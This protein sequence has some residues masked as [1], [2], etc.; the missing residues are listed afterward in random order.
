MSS[1]QNSFYLLYPWLIKYPMIIDILVK[2]RND[3]GISYISQKEIG[4]KLGFSP[5]AISK[6]LRRLEQYDQCVE[7]IAPGQYIVHHTDMMHF[8][9][10]SKVIAFHNAAAKD[11][12][13]LNLDFKHQVEKLGLTREA[14]IMAKHNFLNFVT[15]FEGNKN[16][17]TVLQELEKELSIYLKKYKSL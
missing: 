10:V 2:N 8:G 9:P 16:S 12:S 6:Y 14:V 7:K 3:E 4:K 17:E 13:F 1:I 11:H 5:S 15:R